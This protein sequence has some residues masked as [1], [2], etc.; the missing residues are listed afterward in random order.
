MSPLTLNWSQ[1]AHRLDKICVIMRWCWLVIRFMGNIPCYLEFREH[2]N[3]FLCMRRCWLQHS[4][5]FKLGWNGNK[6]CSS[7]QAMDRAWTA[8]YPLS[9]QQH[10]NRQQQQERQKTI[11]AT[12]SFPP[13]QSWLF[14]CKVIHSSC[15]TSTTELLLH[16]WTL[17]DLGREMSFLG[18]PL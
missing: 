17:G 9:Q 7:I 5:Q 3:H 8:H 15:C 10:R 1:I 14:P 12:Y 2:C 13:S 16:L 6:K 4:L 18:A 11:G